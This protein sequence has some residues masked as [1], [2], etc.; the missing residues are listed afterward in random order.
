MAGLPTTPNFVSS[1]KSAYGA[2]KDFTAQPPSSI[3]DSWLRFVVP[4]ARIRF[5]YWNSL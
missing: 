4:S 3:R 1:A 2:A 5:A